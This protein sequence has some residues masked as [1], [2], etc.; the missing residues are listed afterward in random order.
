MDCN[1][2]AKAMEARGA[3]MENWRKKMPSSGSVRKAADVSGSMV[4]IPEEISRWLHPR[5][6]REFLCFNI[7]D[8]GERLWL[9][10][11][12][13]KHEFEK[14]LRLLFR[15]FF[16]TEKCYG[17]IREYERF[18]FFL[19]CFPESRID[20]WQCG[21]ERCIALLN[22]DSGTLYVSQCSPFSMQAVLCALDSCIGN[23]RRSCLY[24]LKGLFWKLNMHFPENWPFSGWEAAGY[25]L[26]TE[27]NQQIVGDR[28]KPGRILW[29]QVAAE[30][31]LPGRNLALTKLAVRVWF[32][33]QST[34]TYTLYEDRIESGHSDDHERLFAA[35]LALLSVQELKNG[36]F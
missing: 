21:R 28:T 4:R 15:T 13:G 17:C 18:F 11:E 2:N 5:H 12:H 29:A 23:V 35:L 3:S 33:D 24:D 31:R 36:R 26:L 25:T 20:E 34:R 22:R 14:E 16:R 6:F 8:A 1:E 9:I 7:P 10:P 19:S 32:R 30:L 27:G